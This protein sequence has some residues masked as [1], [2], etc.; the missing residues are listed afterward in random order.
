LNS[1][2][3]TYVRTLRLRECVSRIDE[4]HSLSLQAA[5]QCNHYKEELMKIQEKHKAEYDMIQE[6]NQS[7][8]NALLLNLES[9]SSEKNNLQAQINKL[10]K[11]LEMYKDDNVDALMKKEIII[12]NLT[13]ELESSTKNNES[14]T[15]EWSLSQE[16]RNYLENTVKELTEKNQVSDVKLKDLNATLLEM[17]E[18][19]NSKAI[20]DEKISVVNDRIKELEGILDLRNQE[21]DGLKN[22]VSRLNDALQKSV[23]DCENVQ[24]VQDKLNDQQKENEIQAEKFLSSIRNLTNEKEVLTNELMKEKE[25]TLNSNEKI[26]EIQN[27]MKDLVASLLSLEKAKEEEHSEAQ[28]HIEKLSDEMQEMV[29]KRNVLSDENATLQNDLDSL[30]LKNKE[31]E[32]DLLSNQNNEKDNSSN[33]LSINQMNSEKI[34]SLESAILNAKNQINS[35]TQQLQENEVSLNELKNMKDSELLMQNRITDLEN[36][37]GE[38]NINLSI[39]TEKNVKEKE[40]R[41]ERDKVAGNDREKERTDMES[42]VQDLHTQLAESKEEIKTLRDQQLFPPPSPQSSSLSQLP[43]PNGKPSNLPLSPGK[44]LDTDNTLK[45]KNEI[46]ELKLR[47]D[48]LSGNVSALSQ[49]LKLKEG[50]LQLIQESDFDRVDE[51]VVDALNRDKEILEREVARLLGECLRVCVCGCMCECVCVHMCVHVSVC[52]CVCVTVCALHQMGVCIWISVHQKACLPTVTYF[53]FCFISLSC[54]S[55]PTASQTPIHCQFTCYNRR[56][57]G[58]QREAGRFN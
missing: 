33:E 25:N 17:N 51:F 11:D 45:L 38:M 30:L 43:R 7:E 16:K 1:S 8:L 23:V 28:M 13:Q 48:V 2:S 10:N 4:E 39:V 34:E 22:E 40:E 58:H 32:N 14:V 15:K 35:Y 52:A 20:T 27:E 18:N 44:P 49:S 56:V 24:E 57:E 42:K 36:Q 55:S 5:S 29:T 19:A 3:H 26:N 47:N 21:Y 46:E 6:K 37:I 50:E 54:T 41:E 53:Q 12:I 31:L 9:E